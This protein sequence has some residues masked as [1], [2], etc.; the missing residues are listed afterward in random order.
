MIHSHSAY[1]DAEA[2][3]LEGGGNDAPGS[4]ARGRGKVEGVYVRRCSAEF[5]LERAKIVRADFLSGNR[6]WAK[7]MIVLNKRA[8]THG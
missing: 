5:T 7:N 4:D 1:T 8:H 2:D 6:H 3:G